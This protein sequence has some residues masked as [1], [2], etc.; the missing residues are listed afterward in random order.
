MAALLV[1]LAAG[2]SSASSSNSRGSDGPKAVV[3]NRPGP[4]AEKQRA[5]RERAAEL[6][7]TG[8]ISENAKVANVAGLDGRAYN[9]KDRG[10]YVE[11]D[12]TGEDTIWTTLAEFGTGQ[13]THN[14]GA[15]GII[16]HLGTPGPVHNQIPQPDRAVD[17]STIWAPNFNQAYYTNLLFSDAPGQSSMR[18]W[19]KEASS[20]RYAVNG[21]VEDWVQL[22]LNEAAY[23]SNYCGDIVC[24][25][26]IQRFLEDTFTAWYAKQV[27]AGKTATQ[28][29][30][31]LSQ[32]DVWDRYDHDGDGNF[33]EPDGYIDHYQA[34][35]AGAGEETGGGAQ[36]TDAIWSHRS[37]IN[38]AG[39]GSQGPTGNPLGGVRVGSS[40]YWVGDYTVEPENGGVGVFAHEF[41]HD[42]N[43]P[44]EYDTSGNT[45]GAENSTGWWTN[46]S[47]GS[48]GSDG[49]PQD[50]IGNHPISMTAW[51]RL[52]LGWLDYRNINPGDR[53][54]KLILGPTAFNST[55][56]Q[57]AVI[58]LRDKIVAKNVGAPYAG[59]KYY[60]SDT[61]DD[62]DTMMTRSVALPA[63]AT[64]TA[65]VRYN[66]E[67]DWDYA[68]VVVSTDGGAHW[69]TVHTNLSTNESPNGQNFGE[70]ITG[71]SA[72][73][74]WV[75]LSADLSAY[76]GQTVLVGFRYWTDGATQGNGGPLVPGF[77]VDDI[78][79]SGQ[80]LDGAETPVAWD[81]EGDGFHVTTGTDTQA[82][83]NAYIVENRQY[84]GSDKLN[85]GFDQY[86]ASS[87]YN[88][89]TA[90]WT[91]RFTYQNGIVIWYWNTEYANNNVGDHPGEGEILPVDAHPGILRWSD[92][93]AT[94][95]P[96]I[97][98]Y[99][100]AF[101]NQGTPPITLTHKGVQTSFPSQPAQPWFDD[102]LSWWTA[103]SPGDS[104][105]VDATDHYKAAWVSVKVP[106][107]GTKVHVI[108]WPSRDGYQRVDIYPPR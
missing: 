38:I 23:G 51:E 21:T 25:R 82:Y 48:Y 83:H 88:F 43:L 40:N 13:A 55:S 65:K 105:P 2:A 81:F 53:L 64:L 8:K 63:G 94:V 68:Y 99:D 103:S 9:G 44:D 84:V 107:S 32:F 98:S 61:D 28:I 91:E 19:Y 80:P 70:G 71:T 41:G 6:Q 7:L 31:Y 27:A 30:T 35:H 85:V 67:L 22:P 57:A 16:P 29:N 18:N 24:Q 72:G 12:R 66:I 47:Q 86:L 79:I 50:G 36:G 26:D 39:A 76:G 33:N 87:P 89:I 56:E 96:R 14:H 1:V 59:A 93:G 74:T 11:L 4:L 54:T 69:S 101:S 100:A 17:N 3:D 10:Q 102:S 46:W 49:T 106:N 15:F 104:V 34:V 75:S 42:L 90:K 20:N 52:Q 73:N 77:S 108:G 78:A 97:Q 37:Y 60:Y 95:R 92:N 62:L 5:L 58:N 45:G